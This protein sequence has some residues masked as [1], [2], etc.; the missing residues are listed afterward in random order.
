MIR[1]DW[2]FIKEMNSVGTLIFLLTEK[3]PIESLKMRLCDGIIIIFL[4][5]Y[6]EKGVN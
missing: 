2:D 3:I 5:Y 6:D 1:V 4:V